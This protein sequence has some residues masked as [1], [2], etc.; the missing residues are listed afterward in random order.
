M[1]EHKKFGAT[2]LFVLL[3]ILF[4]AINFT[5]IKIALREFSPQQFNG[6]RLF[7]A[8]FIL[9]FVLFIR[10]EGFSVPKSDLW[11][12]IVLGIIGHTAYQLLFIHGLNW[13]TVSNTSIIMAMTPLF[14]ALFST[15][16]KHEK[17]HWAGWLGIFIS[18]IGFYF[19]ITK[20]GESFHFSWEASKGDLMIFTGNILWAVYTVFSKPFLEKIS[21]IKWTSLTLGIG[22]LFYLPFAAADILRLRFNEVS[23]LSWA[24]LI[25]SALFAIAICY[26]IWYTS[27]KRIGNSRTAIYG[28]INPVFSV[29]FAFI[30]LSEQ[31][32]FSQICGAIII[33]GGVYLT[34]S[35]YLWFK[36]KEQ[37]SNAK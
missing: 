2:D 11:K 9:I 27:V 24:A 28:N 4:W 7:L 1:E 6:I 5:F 10:K 34:R 32:T 22:A 36:K 15:L 17:I 25:Y 31:I 18:F 23:S 30:I 26:V 19:V 37:P 8:S 33:F 3:A 14:I 20:Q 12:I 21:P 13:T 35:G 16:L 29:F